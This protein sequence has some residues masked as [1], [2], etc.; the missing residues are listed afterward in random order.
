MQR[1]SLLLRSPGNG[2]Q[3][4]QKVSSDDAIKLEHTGNTLQM[5]KINLCDGCSKHATQ[6]TQKDKRAINRLLA[7]VI[8][9]EKYVQVH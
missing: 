7:R 1:S 3:F 6:G 9:K 8:S 5:T 2:K 4:P